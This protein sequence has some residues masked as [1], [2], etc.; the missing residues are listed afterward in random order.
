MSVRA[1]SGLPPQLAGRRQQAFARSQAALPDL[2][3][4]SSAVRQQQETVPTFLNNLSRKGREKE[5]G[6]GWG[7]ETAWDELEEGKNFHTDK[8][9]TT[10]PVT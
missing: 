9:T 1:T 10:P 5:H 4:S 6:A 7:V 3:F 8:Q 2:L